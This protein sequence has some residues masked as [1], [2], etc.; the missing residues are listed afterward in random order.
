MMMMSWCRWHFLIFPPIDVAII[1][2]TFVM[3][4]SDFSIDVNDPIMNYKIV[5]SVAVVVL[6][7]S[8][9]AVV[10]MRI[11]VRY[12]STRPKINSSPPVPPVDDH[13]RSKMVPRG[14]DMLWWLIVV[15]RIVLVIPIIHPPFVNRSIMVP[16]EM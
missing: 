9:S 10:V 4:E 14:N 6:V 8:D 2:H 11:V 1:S 5:V 13:N 16:K 12:P 7:R 15:M 3:P